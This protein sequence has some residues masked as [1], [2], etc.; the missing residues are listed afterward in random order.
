[1]QPW[2][3]VSDLNYFLDKI[4]VHYRFYFVQWSFQCG[5]FWPGLVWGLL[6][7]EKDQKNVLYNLGACQA[8]KLAEYVSR[9][10]YARM[11]TGNSVLC[12]F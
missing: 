8:H 11:G 12:V 3:V 1:M 5:S 4:S 6:I 9:W 10:D 2:I 7:E